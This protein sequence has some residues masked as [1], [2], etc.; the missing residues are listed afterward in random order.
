LIICGL[1]SFALMRSFPRRQWISVELQLREV[2]FPPLRQQGR[3]KAEV[4]H[5]FRS[6]FAGMTI[7]SEIASQG[8]GADRHRPHLLAFP[9][10]LSLRCNDTHHTMPVDV[11]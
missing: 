11:T 8:M 9:M 2:W 1:L 7:R 3:A 10:H 4:S 6:A 5:V